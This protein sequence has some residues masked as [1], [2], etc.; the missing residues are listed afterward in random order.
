MA[1]AEALCSKL[2]HRLKPVS[3]FRSPRQL[4]LTA[5]MS[6]Y[7]VH[8][9]PFTKH[10]DLLSIMAIIHVSQYF[11][12]VSLLVMILNLPIQVSSFS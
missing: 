9:N 1:P 10:P 5:T 8:K 7:L 2:Q 4:L 6:K 11:E 12:T 3:N